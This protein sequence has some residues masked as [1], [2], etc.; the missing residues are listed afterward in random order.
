MPA[1]HCQME[2]RAPSLEV[3]WSGTTEAPFTSQVRGCHMQ[4]LI[5]LASRNGNSS[6]SSRRLFFLLCLFDLCCMSLNILFNSW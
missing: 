3:V 6:V 5:G 1:S 4:G 2:N